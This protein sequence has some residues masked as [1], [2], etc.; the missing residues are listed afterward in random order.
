MGLLQNDQKVSS[1]KSTST[2]TIYN[3]I[4]QD[5]KQ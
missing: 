2:F 1:I 5:M 3:R 4:A